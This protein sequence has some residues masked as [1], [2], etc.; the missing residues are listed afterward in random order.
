MAEHLELTIVFKSGFLVAGT[1]YI[2]KN[3]NAEIKAM[4]EHEFLP[5]LGELADLR[6]GQDYYGVEPY[7]S[8]EFEPGVFEYLATVEVASIDNL[9]LGMIG[10]EIPR[11]MY[12]VLPAHLD[13]NL[14]E[15][16]HYLH[17]TW[18]SHN[19][20]IEVIASYS[21][22]HYPPTFPKDS[23]LYIHMPIR[24]KRK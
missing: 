11:Q 21:F 15:T 4:W 7:M 10:I 19:S 8:D 1:R 22:E 24:A 17:D 23:I 6:I 20:E 5:R 3:E 13:S 9:P 14:S 16:W 2:G 18:P 12:A